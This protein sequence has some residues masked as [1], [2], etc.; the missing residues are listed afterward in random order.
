MSVSPRRVSFFHLAD[1][2]V[3]AAMLVSAGACFHATSEAPH[4]AAVE[5]SEQRAQATALFRRGF[6]PGVDIV[7]MSRSAF[8]VKIHSGMVGNGDPLY[9]IDGDPVMIPPAGI[10]WFKPDDI[11]Q[12]KVL[13]YPD[14]LALYG[15]RGVNGVIVITTKQARGRSVG[16][17]N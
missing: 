4:P 11:A 10:T 5:A 13:K 2:V 14:E 12:I 3:S 17:A 16:T 8:V 6:F 1:V 9:V 15:P 7:P